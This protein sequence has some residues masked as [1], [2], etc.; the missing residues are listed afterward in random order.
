[1]REKLDSKEKILY[2]A[3]KLFAL[4]G[5]KQTTVRDICAD[6]GS[7]QISINYYF[8]SKENLFKEAL[9]KSFEFLGFREFLSEIEGMSA[10]ER[11]YQIMRYRIELTFACGEKSWF[12]D[13]MSKEFNVNMDLLRPLV[14]QTVAGFLEYLHCVLKEISPEADEFDLQYCCF[15]FMSQSFS[16]AVNTFVR[17]KFFTSD[18]PAPQEIE[19]FA[20]KMT[21]YMLQGLKA[22][23]KEKINE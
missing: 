17:Q 12:F 11:L 18:T 7:Y 13:I 1:M 4:K 8:G 5:F 22:S 16:L 3:C 9:L 21:F 6:S 20:R 14:P 2:S 15:L 23:E 10:E 19:R